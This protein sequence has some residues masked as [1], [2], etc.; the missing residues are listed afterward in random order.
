MDIVTTRPTQP[1]GTE[2]VKIVVLA[3]NTSLGYPSLHLCAKTILNKLIC[4]SK[5]RKI[6]WFVEQFSSGH[7]WLKHLKKQVPT[8]TIQM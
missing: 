5:N 7:T 6:C 8:E 4:V 2:L 3:K 1:R